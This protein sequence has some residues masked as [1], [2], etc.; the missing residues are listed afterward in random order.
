MVTVNEARVSGSHRTLNR[1][2][3]GKA[4]WATS[5]L[6]LCSGIEV[7]G[8]ILRMHPNCTHRSIPVWPAAVKDVQ[9]R[10][11][12]RTGLI[13]VDRTCCKPAVI[14]RRDCVCREG[15]Q[16]ALGEF[17]DPNAGCSLGPIATVSWSERSPAQGHLSGRAELPSEYGVPWTELSKGDG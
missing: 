4:C 9:R 14:P 3:K 17:T 15:D 5:E 1:T 8:A 7:E 16:A 10:R 2:P 11:F 6:V 13:P 12:E